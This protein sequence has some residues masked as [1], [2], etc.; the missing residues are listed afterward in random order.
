MRLLLVFEGLTA[1]LFYS[2]FHLSHDNS[3]YLIATRRFMEGATL[4]VDIIELN[5]PLAFYLTVPGLFIADFAGLPDKVGYVAY[6]CI[7]ATISNL[8]AISI[9]RRSAVEPL[10]KTVL[11]AA[12]PIVTLLL[13][14]SEFGQREHLL[15]IVTLPYFYRSA[16]CQTAPSSLVERIAIGV[17]ATLGFALKPYFYAAALT[18]TLARTW[19][20]RSLRPLISVT[21]IVIAAMTIA[22]L[23]FVFVMHREYVDEIVPLA[24]AVYHSY[25]F[26]IWKRLAQPA[27]LAVPVL[28]LFIVG[29]RRQTDQTNWLFIAAA[30]GF[31]LSYFLQFKGWN[32]QILPSAAYLFISVA[33][34][35]ACNAKALRERLVLAV[36]VMVAVLGTLGQQII[37][38]PYRS[39]TLASFE[40]FVERRGMSILVISSNLSASFPFVN[41]VEGTWSSRLPAQ[42]IV[43][44]AIAAKAASNCSYDRLECSRYD[45]LLAKARTIMIEDFV[46]FE[47]QIVFIDERKSKDYFGGQDFNYLDFLAQDKRFEAIWSRYD[48]LDRG[49]GY[50][51][52]AKGE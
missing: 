16:L 27:F 12:A 52:W 17:F 26:P 7:L 36:A 33:M 23:A 48:E 3:W 5:P 22:Y 44:G 32:Y 40:P 39:T 46:Q 24:T 35:S 41:E 10:R 1:A 37:R 30:A 18:V 38:G 47:P 15:I 34:L 8:W 19:Q 51:V 6:V 45:A 9:V 50:S 14:I 20:D 4:Y 28:L 2:Q 25:G 11:F 49:A 31:V 42:W 21:N 43:P 13:P 29:K